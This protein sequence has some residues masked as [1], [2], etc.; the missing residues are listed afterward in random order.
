MVLA[1]NLCFSARA[2]YTKLMSSALTISKCHF[3]ETNLFFA[4]SLRGLLFLVP[5]TAFFEGQH[6][7][8]AFYNSR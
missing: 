2:V 6:V 7:L 3:D 1:S 5:I 4:I 8:K